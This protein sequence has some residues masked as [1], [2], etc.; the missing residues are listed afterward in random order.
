ML[1]E[2]SL[3]ELKNIIRV[4]VMRKAKSS[5]DDSKQMEILKGQVSCQMLLV[6]V[7]KLKKGRD[8]GAR[9]Q[10]RVPRGMG[11]KGAFRF[12]ENLISCFSKCCFRS[13]R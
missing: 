5:K 2:K 1:S 4:I 12:G 3:A 10:E 6:Y 13:V 11:T 7:L 9:I 8:G